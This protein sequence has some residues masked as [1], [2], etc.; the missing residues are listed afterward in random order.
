MPTIHCQVEEGKSLC[1]KRKGL[2]TDLKEFKKR[3]K[4]IFFLGGCS[5]CIEIVKA[6]YSGKQKAVKEKKQPL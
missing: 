3:M 6:K 1:G 2:S 5:K 4:S